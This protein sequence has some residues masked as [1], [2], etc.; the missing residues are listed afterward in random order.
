MTVNFYDLLKEKRVRRELKIFPVVD[1][2]KVSESFI[3]VLKIITYD[4][5]SNSA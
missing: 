5:T 1:M 4:C 2:N 3:G